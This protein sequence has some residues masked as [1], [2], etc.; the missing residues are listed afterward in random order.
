MIPL[1]MKTRTTAGPATPAA[2]PQSA[3]MPA[4]I[5]PPTPI[6]V[7]EKS[8]RS[9]L[10]RTSTGLVDFPFFDVATMPPDC[11][12]AIIRQRVGLRSKANSKDGLRDPAFTS[13][14]RSVRMEAARPRR[15]SREPFAEFQPE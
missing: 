3:K 12:G 7:T 6:M 8:P 10:S 14:A 9:R 1:R 15:S 2:M 5:M 13:D 4:P 11:F